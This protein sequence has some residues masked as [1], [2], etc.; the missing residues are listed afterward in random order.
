[1]VKKEIININDFFIHTIEL[2][3]TDFVTRDR[4][5]FSVDRGG[6]SRGEG[7]GETGARHL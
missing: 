7:W 6:D 2:F 1:M 5:L 3:N 4:F